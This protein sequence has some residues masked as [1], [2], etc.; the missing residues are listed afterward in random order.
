MSCSAFL[1]STQVGT[2]LCILNFF[3]IWLCC[4]KFKHHPVYLL[5]K[6]DYWCVRIKR[7]DSFTKKKASWYDFILSPIYL[8]WGII[9]FF[10][11]FVINFA[12]GMLFK[13]YDI[14][15]A[16]INIL[17]CYCFTHRKF[18]VCKV[19][20]ESYIELLICCLPNFLFNLCLE[21]N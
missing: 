9:S 13:L 18:D 4:T 20:G 19:L 6:R 21:V 14:P 7:Y 5:D 8:I 3:C 1:K 16:I 12:F 15:I 2:N 11:M 10:V 17:C